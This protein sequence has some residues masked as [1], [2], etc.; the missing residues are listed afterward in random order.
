MSTKK[1]TKDNLPFLIIGAV[2]VVAIL[3]GIWFVKFREP[4]RKPAANN[5]AK[6]AAPA[7]STALAKAPAGAIPPNMRGSQTASVTLEEFADYQCPTCATMHPVM[8]EVVSYY[9]S[10]IKFIYRSFP[11]VQIH[12]KAY[13]AAV[14]AEAA[15]IQGKFWDMQNQLFQNQ[16]SWAA[17]GADHK[18]LFDEYAKLIGLDVEKFKNDAAG[19][20]AKSRVDADLTRARGAQIASTP[21]LFINGVPVTMEQMTVQ[22]IKQLVDAEIQKFQPAPTESTN[23]NK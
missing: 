1:E 10:K 13:D 21:S 15:G 19:L 6:T 5:G 22:G 12:D 9:G 3:L 8:N 11:L 23:T 4:E 16:K 2:A 20:V 14:A 17:Q 7:T 18:A